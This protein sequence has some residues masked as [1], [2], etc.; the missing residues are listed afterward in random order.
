MKRDLQSS[1]RIAGVAVALL[2]AIVLPNFVSIAAQEVFVLIASFALL[3][4]GLNVV[5]G[6]AGLLDLGYVAFFAT[7]AYTWAILSGAG[8]TK[9]GFTQTAF[10]EEWGFW[11]ILAFVLVINMGIGVLLG[12]PTLRLRGDYLAIVT[13]G[14][15]EIVRIVASNLDNLSGGAQGISGVPH[16]TVPVV[17]FG[18]GLNPLPY[19]YLLIALL[20]LGTWAIRGLDRSRIGR[21]WVAIREDEV[22]AEAMGIPTLKMKLMAFAIGAVTAGFAGV[23]SAAKINFISPPSFDI[24]FSI[25]ILAAVVLGGMGSIPGS[26]VGAFIIAGIPALVQL[27]YS[28]FDEFRYWAFGGLLVTMMIFRP[29]GLIPSKRRAAELQPES[30]AD[31]VV[32]ESTPSARSGTEEKA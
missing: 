28:R 11:L 24:F 6:F 13:L 7:G 17:G 23:V 4:L 2:M 16:P 19:L 26:L 32:E 3:T 22:A 25:L 18:F 14:F 15:G 9:F 12:S 30:E 29:Q 20:V 5:V 27:R 8:P 1:I 31:A 10:W 21:A